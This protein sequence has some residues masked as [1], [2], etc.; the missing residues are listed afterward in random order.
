MSYGHLPCFD[1]GFCQLVT[2]SCHHV[3]DPIWARWNDLWALYL[4]SAHV[5]VYRC[6]TLGDDRYHHQ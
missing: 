2:A 4:G 5:H 6:R 1:L 3:G